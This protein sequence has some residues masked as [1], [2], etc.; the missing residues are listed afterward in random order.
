LEV[1]NIAPYGYYKKPSASKSTPFD[2]TIWAPHDYKFHD[3]WASI[4]RSNVTYRI[5][6]EGFQ[7]AKEIV[8]KL[9]AT[10]YGVQAVYYD[11]FNK[12]SRIRLWIDIME[13]VQQLR[14]SKEQGYD[15]AIFAIHELSECMPMLPEGQT[16]SLAQEAADLFLDFRKDDILTLAAYQMSSEV[17]Y[18]FSFKWSFVLQKRPVL[19]RIMQPYEEPARL[20]TEADVNIMRDGYWMQHR[21]GN[22]HELQDAYRLIPQRKK[23]LYGTPTKQDNIKKVRDQRNRAYA[24]IIDELGEPLRK[25]A[26]D[27]REAR[28]FVRDGV[29]RGRLVGGENEEVETQ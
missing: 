6:E 11:C 4:A 21:I 7:D 3:I 12:A 22:I 28:D 18:R 29:E 19:K 14:N 1:R 23:L 27:I 10:P 24:Y 15:P 13:Q 5:E 8:E 26:R 25:V 16:W 2:I 20:F 9:D 17:Y